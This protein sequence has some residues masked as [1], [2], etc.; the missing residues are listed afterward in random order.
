MGDRN[1]TIRILIDWCREDFLP[2][3]HDRQAG[4]Q[5][6]KPESVDDAHRNQSLPGL[7]DLAL[8]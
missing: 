1:K 6:P 7:H 4:D 8:E 2:D 3:E 5:H